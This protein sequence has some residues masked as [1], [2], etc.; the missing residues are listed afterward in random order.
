[1]TCCSPIGGSNRI[2]IYKARQRPFRSLSCLKR[3]QNTARV[4]QHYIFLANWNKILKH[5]LIVLESLFSSKIVLV[6]V[7]LYLSSC[8]PQRLAI[9]DSSL[10]CLLRAW[11]SFRSFQ[12]SNVSVDFFKFLSIQFAACSKPPSVEIIIIKRILWKTHI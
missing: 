10:H 9:A 3:L 8:H 5:F 7:V 1:M 4:K 6:I 11:S 12:W 2:S